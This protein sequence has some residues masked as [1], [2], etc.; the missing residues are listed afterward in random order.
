MTTYVIT[1]AQTGLPWRQGGSVTIPEPSIAVA[2]SMT[3]TWATIAQRALVLSCP[4]L[5]SY[6][7]GQPQTWTYQPGPVPVG[8]WM[9]TY[10]A[11][12]AAIGASTTIT[13]QESATGQ[14]V[15]AALLAAGNQFD[16]F[17]TAGVK[18]GLLYALQRN[19]WTQVLAQPAWLDLD[20]LCRYAYS[21]VASQAGIVQAA[22]AGTGP[23]WSASTSF[24]TV[25]FNGFAYILTPGYCVPNPTNGF[26]YQGYGTTGGYQPSWPTT[27]GATVRDTSGTFTWTCVAATGSAGAALPFDQTLAAVTTLN[28]RYL[29]AQGLVSANP[30][31]LSLLAVAQTA[32]ATA[33][34]AQPAA[35]PAADAASLIVTTALNSA[36]AQAQSWLGAVNFQ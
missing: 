3:A 34:A 21:S 11:I 2:Q 8:Y 29:A 14:T 15:A 35:N 1:D 33:L 16:Y 10:E 22:F 24:G 13:S 4:T 20:R 26:V 32:W 12:F 31:L 36:L 5:I 19:A 6:P 17:S 30:A 23:A 28:L 18:N 25:L 9:A 27:I 7:N